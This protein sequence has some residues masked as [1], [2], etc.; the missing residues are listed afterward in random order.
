MNY[1]QAI[2]T[3]AD[4]RRHPEADREYVLQILARPIKPAPSLDCTGCGEA[5]DIE[6]MFDYKQQPHTLI[7]C[8]ICGLDEIEP[9]RL[10]RWRLEP[11]AVLRQIFKS[12]LPALQP[13][14]LVP[15]LVWQLGRLGLH[16]RQRELLY[17]RQPSRDVDQLAKQL[18]R[19]RPSNIVFTPTDVDA[20]AWLAELDNQ[21]ISLESIS[22]FEQAEIRFDQAF[23]LD[24]IAARRVTDSKVPASPK[25]RQSL[26]LKISALKR[27][28][29]DHMRAARAHAES[30][31]ERT[32]TPELLP[33]PTNQFLAKQTGMEDYDVTRC[34]KDPRAEDLRTLKRLAQDLEAVLPN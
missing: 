6:I 14:E 11:T 13:V 8:P 30:T 32:G 29:E 12:L 19:K 17:V 24:Q 31:L 25:R 33:F 28:I 23:F 3:M 34:F 5:A 2:L 1:N 16:G 22:S 15:S 20:A 27:A 7:I 18:L 10:L 26:M 21:V 4:F 9:E